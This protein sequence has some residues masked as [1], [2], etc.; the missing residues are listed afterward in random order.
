MLVQMGPMRRGP[1]V[2]KS[3]LLVFLVILVFLLHSCCSNL[4]KNTVKIK[5]IL[6]QSAEELDIEVQSEI[7]TCENRF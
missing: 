1:I 7:A 3:A 4:H 5:V 2:F 6:I